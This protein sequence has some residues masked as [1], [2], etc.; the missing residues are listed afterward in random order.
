MWSFVKS[1]VNQR[2]LWHAIDS[3]SGKV[4]AYVLASRKDEA[5]QTLQ[6]LLKPSKI[7]VFCTDD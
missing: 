1:K 6:T 3:I 4:L 7:K 2:W 5:F